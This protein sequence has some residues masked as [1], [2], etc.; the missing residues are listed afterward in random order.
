MKGDRYSKPGKN[1]IGGV[2]QRIPEGFV[3]TEGTSQHDD[4]SFK[5]VNP[6]RQHDQAGRE[7]RQQNI[8]DRYQDDFDPGWQGYGGCIHAAL[9]KAFAII[10]PSVVLSAS[11]PRT[12]P[13]ILP[14]NITSMRSL[15][16]MISSSS[17]DT[18]STAQPASRISISLA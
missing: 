3:I 4:Y 7:Q 6:D 11:A 13:T 14:S 8:Q 2:I 5:R 18:S 15:R 9:S 1:K 12:S 10:S 16:A 17:T